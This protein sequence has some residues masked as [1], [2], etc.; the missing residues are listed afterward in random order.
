MALERV[1]QTAACSNNF[2]LERLN[3]NDQMKL[4]LL[5]SE[6][7]YLLAMQRMSEIVLIQTPQYDFIFHRKLLESCK[8]PSLCTRS[9]IQ[10]GVYVQNPSGIQ[11]QVY[12]VIF[13]RKKTTSWTQNQGVTCKA[14]LSAFN[15][16]HSTFSTQ[17]SAFKVQVSV[18]KQYVIIF[19]QK[20][21]VL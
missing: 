5:D 1:I 3:L 14:Q 19:V 18:F 20:M 6:Q 17:H 9:L 15:I 21:P 13:H 16:Q 2:K 4:E 10:P 12:D 8:L 7:P 11:H